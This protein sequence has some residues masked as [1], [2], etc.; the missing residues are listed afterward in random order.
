MQTTDGRIYGVILV[1]SRSGA[2]NGRE[3][4]MTSYGIGIIGFGVMGERLAAMI[5]GDA[6]GL[7]TF[8]EAFDVQSCVEAMLRGT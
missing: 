8:Q 2:A 4:T 1:R 7:A 6:H 5:R 3:Q